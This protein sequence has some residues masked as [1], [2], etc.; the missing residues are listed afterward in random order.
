MLRRHLGTTALAAFCLGLC[1]TARAAE[2]YETAGSVENAV[3]DIACMAIYNSADLGKALGVVPFALRGITTTSRHWA[4]MT[5]MQ[6]DQV[7][8]GGATGQKVLATATLSGAWPRLLAGNYADVAGAKVPYWVQTAAAVG[9]L[10]LPPLAGLALGSG[11]TLL[12]WALGAGNALQATA[13]DVAVLIKSGG[14]L[15]RHFA[16]STDPQGKPWLNQQLVFRTTVNTQ[17]RSYV[18]CSARYPVEMAS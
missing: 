1:S 12:D 3:S 7:T 16:L 8:G 18:L 10:P 6:R 14:L 17:I 9:A 11:L 4:R 15:E 2:W 5:R 13:N